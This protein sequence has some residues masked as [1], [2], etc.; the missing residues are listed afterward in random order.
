MKTKYKVI[1][2]I[3]VVLIL[4]GISIFS[5]AAE[6]LPQYRKIVVASAMKRNIAQTLNLQGYI[7]P[8]SKQEI[9][10]NINQK[11]EEVYVQEGQTVK[12]GDLLLKL[13]ESDNAYKLKSEELN[14]K[15]AQNELNNL[16]KSE[17]EDKK[18]IVYSVTQAE[19]QYK[20][21]VDELAAAK[22]NFEQNQEL[23]LEGFVSKE[24]LDNSERSLSKLEGAV[25][26]SEIQLDKAR[27]GLNSYSGQRQL[28][29]DKLRSNIELIKM[30]VESLN[31]K[32]DISSKA[33]IDGIVVRCKLQNNQYPTVEN[34]TV[35]I[36]DLSRYVISAYVKQN[37]A[38]QLAEGSKAAI[39]IK[40]LEQKSY[41]GTVID[42]EDT[43][44]LSQGSSKI[45]MVKI[46]VA[47]DEPDQNVK[48]GFE[49]EVKID[50]N[51]K[52]DVVVVNFQAIVEDESGNR[53]V[54]FFKDNKA[55]RKLVRT[56]IESG[57]LVEIVE[58]LIP[59]DQYILNPPERVQDKES[60]KLWSWGYE[61]Q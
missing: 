19:I 54:Y 3:A 20:N 55:D 27:E 6:K 34:T 52:S 31:T 53:F 43:A 50:L 18:E 41:I 60:F 1:I 4:T 16:L 57:I 26:L 46:K 8:N 29:I 7:E 28:Q 47:L 61:L 45:P 10:L 14:L 13:D 37:E 49:T 21:S 44:T 59:G 39:T 30:N 48:V 35:E 17:N 5:I 23:Y 32:I 56:G 40:G 15:I 42:V 9:T 38:V 33:I 22:V 12:V 36:Y 2:A 11:V 51:V 58:G 25:L 24:E